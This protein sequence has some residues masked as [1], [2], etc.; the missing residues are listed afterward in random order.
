MKKLLFIPLLFLVNACTTVSEAGYYWG[1]YAKTSYL[2]VDQ[3]SDNSYRTHV[4]ELN[5][6]IQKSQEKNLN[7]PPGIHAELGFMLS[8]LGEEENANAQFNLEMEKYPESAVFLNRLLG[9]QADEDEDA[10]E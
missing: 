6:I 8:K 5:Q 3:P 4:E 9:E 1:N 7:V 10:N 2:I